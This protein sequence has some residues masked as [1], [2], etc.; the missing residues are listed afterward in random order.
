MARSRSAVAMAALAVRCSAVA[1]SGWLGKSLRNASPSFS[2]WSCWPAS[3][4]SHNL[5]VG[6]PGFRQD[7]RGDGFAGLL[8]LPETI[9]P[10]PRGS[11]LAGFRAD[12]DHRFEEPALHGVIQGRFGEFERGGDALL[13][14]NRRH[15]G[16]DP[17]DGQAALPAAS[18][19]PL[20]WRVP[21]RR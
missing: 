12:L 19:S 13:F 16:R 9:L 8:R 15:Q 14:G 1:I 4:A 11:V 18:W 10:E 7:G 20:R 6:F 21:G 3:A 5:P 17:F 2:A